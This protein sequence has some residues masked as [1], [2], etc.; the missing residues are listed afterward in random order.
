[1]NTGYVL[2]HTA[3]RALAHGSIYMAARVFRSVEVAQPLYVPAAAFAQGLSDSA[4]SEVEQQLHDL[5]SAPCFVFR[6]LDEASCWAAAQIA[7]E[8]AT[9]IATGHAAH[10]ALRSGLPVLTRTPD[11]YKRIDARIDSEPVS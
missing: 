5:L 2:D 3:V 7:H 11:T 8:R 6:P 4:L 9:D 10:L 1:M